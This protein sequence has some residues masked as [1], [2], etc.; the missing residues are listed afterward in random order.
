MPPQ[1][2]ARDE[3]PAQRSFSDRKAGKGGLSGFAVWASPGYAGTPSPVVDFAEGMGA[4]PGGGGGE[5]DDEAW[6][7]RRESNPW[8]RFQLTG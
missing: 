8:T 7:R 3:R 5:A 1:H 4:C 2:L 6:W